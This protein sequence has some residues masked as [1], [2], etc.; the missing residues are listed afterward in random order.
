MNNFEKTWLQAS[1]G[2]RNKGFFWY[3]DQHN[4]LKAMAGYY[5][6]PFNVVCGITA[7]LSPSISWDVNLNAVRLLLQNKGKVS[8]IK[9]TGYPLNWKKAT[10]MYRNRKVFP[11][12]SGDK[13]TAFYDNLLKPHASTKVAIDTFMIACYYGYTDKAN[14]AKHFTP[15]YNKVLQDEIKILAEKYDRSPC[16][17]QATIWIAYHRIVRS[18]QSYDYQLELKI[19]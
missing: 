15:K 13:V 12:L 4:Y 14:C 6:I 2:E 9:T 5:G 8:G 19:F 18:M 10:R 16:Q 7:V 3:S 11:Y 1:E 17:M